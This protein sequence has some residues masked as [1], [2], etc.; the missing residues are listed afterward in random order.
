[1]LLPC[2]VLQC[3]FSCYYPS[4]CTYSQS[5]VRTAEM[6][7]A[8]DLTT[9]IVPLKIQRYRKISKKNFEKIL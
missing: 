6:A 5:T 3:R 9:Q 4:T 8:R 2:S 7:A 1:M